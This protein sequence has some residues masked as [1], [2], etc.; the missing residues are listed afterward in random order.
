MRKLS[1]HTTEG[2]TFLLQL[3]FPFATHVKKK[4]FSYFDRQSMFDKIYQYLKRQIAWPDFLRWK[5]S[6]SREV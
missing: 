6:V 2:K 4:G 3:I 5:G 1:T